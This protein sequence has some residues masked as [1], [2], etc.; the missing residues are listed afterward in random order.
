MMKTTNGTLTAV[1]LA[2]GKGSRL[3]PHT[4][5][6][7]KPL[8]EVGGRP[9]VEYLLVRLRKGGVGRVI[10]AVNHLAEQIEHR[11]GDGSR[12]DLQIEYSH[13]TQPLSTVAPLK[14]VKNLPGDFLVANGDIITDLDIGALYR[15]HIEC[16]AELTV[17]TYRGIEKIDFGVLETDSNNTVTGFRE[18]PDYHFIVSM[19]IYV[20]SRSV[21]DL[22]PDNKP[23]G[24]D[25]LI[26]DMLKHKRQV[27]SFLHDGFWL[28]IGR[29]ADYE[30]AQGETER[31]KGKL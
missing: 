3:M 26:L 5:D 10:M 23:Y 1:V 4:A 2:G 6:I 13:E 28:D 12:F 27:C 8:V 20:F 15:N 21:L 31:I 7:P 9:V 25:Q 22:V 29:P 17:A 24:F 14:L 16:G 19:G 18:K 30:K 11:L